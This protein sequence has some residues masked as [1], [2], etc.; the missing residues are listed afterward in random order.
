MSSAGGAWI[1]GR[2]VDLSVF[3]GSAALA[4]ALGIASP[5]LTRG[6]QLPEWAWFV[7]VVGLDVAHVWST[8]YR[9][10][11]DRDELSKRKL[12]YVA[13][14]LA[15]YALGVLMYSVDRL[16]FWRVFAYVAVFHFIRQQ[17]GWVAIYRAR[18]GE[19]RR[20]D[21]LLDDVVVYAA[22]L[23]PL[24]YWH[25]NL[26]LQFEWFVAGDFVDLRLLQPLVA[27]LGAVYVALLCAYVVH[28]L[29]R[30]REGNAINTGKH[31]VV[32][33]T[34]II[35]FVGIVAMDEDFGFTVTNVTIHAVPYF[36]L[37]WMYARERAKERPHAL[38]A[39]VV[40]GGVVAFFT[41][42]LVLAFVEELAWERLVWHDRPGWFGG[43]ERDAPL[44]GAE[45][46]RWLVPFL[47]LP[48]AVHYALDGFLWRRRDTGP[49]QAR[50][51]GFHAQAS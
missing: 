2:R 23:W 24:L 26:P 1:W 30:W 44:L 33:T 22:T 49:A 27:P 7:F 47:A 6:G 15:C 20:F 9:T 25:A 28:Y 46:L 29:R 35:W 36:A 42:A 17:V 3:A 10:Y 50:A 12:L 19:S 18:A 31:L 16:I 21:R 38:V 45:A 37:L 13:L 43:V 40:K 32:A 8:L 14:P 48:Q 51:L 4:L 41:V 5:L 39:R 34:A 11:L